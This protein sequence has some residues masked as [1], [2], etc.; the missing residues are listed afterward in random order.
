MSRC[1][2]ILKRGSRCHL[3]AITK[4]DTFVFEDF[5]QSE[6]DINSPSQ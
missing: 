1:D 3:D 4:V 6:S 5:G 2:R